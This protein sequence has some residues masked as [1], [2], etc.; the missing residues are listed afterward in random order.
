[1]AETTV[2]GLPVGIG[3]VGDAPAEAVM[4]G[5]FASEPGI[6][7]AQERIARGA[8]RAGRDPR[9]VPLISWLYVAVDADPGAAR[10]RVKR[11]LATAIFGSRGVLDQIGIRLPPALADLLGQ[12]DY[13]VLADPATARRVMGLIPDD[14]VGHLAVAGTVDDVA[15]QLAG[16]ARLGVGELAIWPFPPD[17]T[18]WEHEIVPLAEEVMPRVQRALEAQGA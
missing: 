3:I 18:D 6:R 17:G 2:R 15:E 5:T 1:M 11:G 10:G 7:Y 8:A 12:F 14:L 16:I 9:A 4:I 13:D